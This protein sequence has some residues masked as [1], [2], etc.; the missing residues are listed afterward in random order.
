MNIRQNLKVLH[1]AH[2]AV[3]TWVV[4][5]QRLHERS[6]LG[7]PNTTAEG[8]LAAGELPGMGSKSKPRPRAPEVALHGEALQ[9]D[10][11]I[12]ELPGVFQEAIELFYVRGVPLSEGGR[13][14]KKKY[15]TPEK[16]FSSLID[17]A[18]MFIAGYLK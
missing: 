18:L 1:D 11:A 15:G 17:N 9:V 4:A 12:K 6:T 5:T 7:F 2:S 3:Q 8:R 14:L 13:T 16:S 10:R